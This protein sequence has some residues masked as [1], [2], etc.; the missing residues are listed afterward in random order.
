M[1][2]DKKKI[3]AKYLREMGKYISRLR[4]LQKYKKEEFISDWKIQHL[5]ERELHLAL[6]SMT[7]IGEM[8]IGE[9][10][11]RKPETYKEIIRIL[12]ENKVIPAKYQKKFEELAG[13]RNILIHD[14]LYLD[15]DKVYQHLKKDPKYLEEFIQWVKKTIR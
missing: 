15:Y 13:F 2:K 11:W 12:V 6:E 7:N 8:L 9:F 14:Y 10:N 5:I 1:S 4:E 3:L